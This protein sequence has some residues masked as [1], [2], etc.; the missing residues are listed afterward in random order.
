[1]SKLG[2]QYFFTNSDIYFFHEVSF[3]T[4]FQTIGLFSITGHV[5][6]IPGNGLGAVADEGCAMP[7]KKG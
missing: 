2:V 1:M 6:Q 5:T 4:C 7:V 3:A